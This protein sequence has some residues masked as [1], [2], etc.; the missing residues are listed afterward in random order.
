MLI[1]HDRRFMET[2]SRQTLWLDR[3]QTKIMRRNFKHFEN[4]RDDVLEQEEKAAHKL[5]RKIEREEHWVYGSVT[6]RR[7]M[8]GASELAALKNSAGSAAS[9]PL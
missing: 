4:W 8:S 1:S 7:G 5:D 6:A 2:V 3:G 9:R